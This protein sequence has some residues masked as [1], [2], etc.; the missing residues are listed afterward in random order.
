MAPAETS[1]GGYA[2]LPG[3]QHEADPVF[4]PAND[5]FY[6]VLY[7]YSAQV[8]ISLNTRHFILRAKRGFLTSLSV[9][10]LSSLVW[11]PCPALDSRVT[12]SPRAP[13]RFCA[14]SVVSRCYD[15]RIKQEVNSELWFH[16]RGPIS[17]S[18][19]PGV[20]RSSRTPQLLVFKPPSARLVTWSRCA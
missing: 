12:V 10:S 7:Q 14:R 16:T 8:L 1:D 18:V 9:F 17:E 5:D 11:S 4:L 6:V 20:P 19:S 3:L 2:P 13:R 15:F